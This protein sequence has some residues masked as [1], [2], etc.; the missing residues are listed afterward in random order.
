MKTS[1]VRRNCDHEG[2]R[3]SRDCAPYAVYHRIGTL[4]NGFLALIT[5]LTLRMEPECAYPH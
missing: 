4:G 2:L 1:L 5:L 3:E